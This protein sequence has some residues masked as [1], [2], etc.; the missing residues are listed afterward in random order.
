MTQKKTIVDVY[1]DCN[2]GI[3]TCSRSF[4]ASTRH[5]DNIRTAKIW[6]FLLFLIKH[7]F[8]L[9]CGEMVRT[10]FLRCIKV[11]T[12]LLKIAWKGRIW[13]TSE[14]QINSSFKTFSYVCLCFAERIANAREKPNRIIKLL[15]PGSLKLS[16]L[17]QA[18]FLTNI[19]GISLCPGGRGHVKARCP[20][21]QPTII[22]S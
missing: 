15:S 21:P 1:I 17:G 8:Q 6:E 18:L 13:Y 11:G 7:R 12:I 22:R 10:P 4:V 19:W 16:E 20:C 3:G 2:C 14:K 5:S 9:I